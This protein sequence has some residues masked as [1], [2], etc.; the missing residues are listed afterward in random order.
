MKTSTLTKSIFLKA[1]PEHVWTFL[2]DPEKISTWFHKPDKP[3]KSDASFEMIGAES[4]KAFMWGKVLRAE[5]PKFLS[6]EF[7]MPQ[8]NGHVTTVTCELT[9]VPGGTQLSLEHSNLPHTEETFGLLQSLDKGWDGHLSDLR[10]E[11]A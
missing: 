1:S 3:L 6:Y 2:T 10:K 11:A 5:E 8:L 7:Q 4:G 9:A